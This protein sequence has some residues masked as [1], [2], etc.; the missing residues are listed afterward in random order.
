M[1]YETN[2]QIYDFQQHDIT[3]SF[4]DNIY[5]G[6]IS[7]NKAGTDKTNLL[8]NMVDFHIKARPKAKEGKDI[9]LIA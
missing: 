1:K 8:E 5:I 3:R 9:L 6:K 2:W 7:I 4:G